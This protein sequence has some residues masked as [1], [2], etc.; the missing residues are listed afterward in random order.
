LRLDWSVRPGVQ[1]E[2]RRQ[3]RFELYLRTGEERLR[4]V[5]FPA[6]TEPRD[7]TSEAIGLA[8]GTRYIAAVGGDL[9]IETGRGINFVPPAGQPPGPADRHRGELE[10]ALRLGRRLRIDTNYLFTRLADPGDGEVILTNHI[11]RSRFGWQFNRKLSLRAILRYDEIDA[12]PQKTRLAT[13]ENFNADLLVTYLINPWTAAYVGYNSNYLS[14]EIVDRGDGPEL[15]LSEDEFLN[16][17]R[18]LFFKIT[19]LFRL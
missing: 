16:N 4:P 10:L 1:W 13:S 19:Y 17:A 5:D 6:L 3:T 11:L 7:Y 18:Q 2:F 8:F 14:A 15:L 9:F 12:D